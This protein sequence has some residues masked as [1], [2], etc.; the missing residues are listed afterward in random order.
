MKPF[1]TSL[2]IVMAVAS[3]RVHGGPPNTDHLGPE[4]APHNGVFVCNGDT[5]IFNGDGKTVTWSFSSPV[6]S[7]T[8]KGEGS[9][10]FKMYHGQFRYDA[11]EY[12]SIYD[13]KKSH[14]YYTGPGMNTEDQI[15]F[16]YFVGDDH[17]ERTFK[18]V[19]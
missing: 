4:P 1:F 15:S 7:L 13:G 9:Y 16:Y 19:K 12:F 14:T 18:K 8:G 5:L 2:L 11:A 3:C 6:D 10:V 17:Q